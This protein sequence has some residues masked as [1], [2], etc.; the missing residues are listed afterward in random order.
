MPRFS[1]FGPVGLC[2]ALLPALPAAGA[3][4]LRDTTT[5]HEAMS[6][7][8]ADALTYLQHVTTLSNPFFEGRGTGTAG[9]ERAQDYLQFHF[10]RLGLKP[11]FEKTVTLPDGTEVVEAGASYRQAF[12]FATAAEVTA[13]GLGIAG[14]PEAEGDRPTFVPGRDFNVLGFS[15]TG[16]VEGPV[17]FVG[18]SIGD[19][20]DGYTSYPDDED[21]SGKIAL[22][23]RFEPVNEEGRSAFTGGRWSGHAGL[24]GKI[25]EAAERNAAAIILVSPPGASDP[26]TNELETA[27]STASY[28]RRGLEIP[29]VMVTMD[30]ADRLLQR[31]D[32]QKRTLAD[33]RK[34]ADAGDEGVIDLGGA[35]VTVQAGIERKAAYSNNM[36]A[37]LPG[38]GDLAKEYIVIGAH[39]DHVGRG[40][41][42]GRNPAEYG[43]IHPGADD[44]ASGTSGM[45][46]AAEKLA[47]AYANLPPQ[48][49]VRSVLFLG[50]SGE[51]IGLIGSRYFASN[52]P[53]AADDMFLMINMDMIGRLR[54]SL[55]V[56]GV[57]T[58][59]GLKELLLPHFDASG[60]EISY[61]PG[62]TGPSD[63]TNFYNLGV[64]VLFFFTGLHHEYHTPADVVSLINV[65]GAARVIDLVTKVV[66]DFADNEERLEFVAAGRGRRPRMPP[67]DEP[68]Q[69][70]AAGPSRME[71]KVRFG[72]APGMYGESS[73]GV[74]VGQVMPETSAAEAGVQPG[75]RLITWNG[76]E[77]MDVA[78]WMEMLAKHQPGDTV[79]VGILRDGSEITLPVTLKASDRSPR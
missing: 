45:L 8:D 74:L 48:A 30:A 24:M 20:P 52:S 4:A 50:F 64:P 43:T 70:Q 1:P 73:G 29:V 14:G 62:G 47:A 44:N 21:L 3:E 75:D 34:L 79:Q 28:A 67:A 12:P 58:A 10:E 37:I 76:V 55:D 26:R 13:E 60:L 59:E 39:F 9:N 19:G 57:E 71:M 69:P 11:A 27:E 53:I 5:I 2:L 56:Q 51:E 18:Y 63:H 61:T 23:L 78:G 35:P 32:A 49:S 17:A 54:E 6:E 38:R 33:L 15:G 65:D 77:I 16:R 46:L 7:A 40:Y 72:I 31:V 25:S 42:G 22:M 66:L 68:G 36:G 41:Q